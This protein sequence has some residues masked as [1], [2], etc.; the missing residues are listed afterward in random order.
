[1]ITVL[2]CDPDKSERALLN[3][4]CRQQIADSCG[5][6]LR[7]DNVLD[8]EA[9]TRFAESEPLVHLLY[10]SFHRGQSVQALR[11]FR[12]RCGEAMVMLITDSSVSPLEYL[13]PGIAPDSLALRPLDAVHLNAVNREF[14]SSF[15]ERL[16]ESGDRF[17][18][19]ARDE[20]ILIPWSRIYYF[21]ARNK[22]LFVRTRHEEYA[23]NDTMDRLEQSLPDSFQRCHRSYIV[24]AAKIV[25][26]ILPEGFIELADGLSVPVSR[27]YRACF[28]TPR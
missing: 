27:R 19:S 23:F 26:V 6:D 13:R 18:V 1:M 17:I 14:V 24:N 15:L 25:R 11:M 12:K 5:E 9:L 8:D 22:K 21:E 4:E 16:Q 7:L 20:K 10:Y 28:R 3:R 2:V